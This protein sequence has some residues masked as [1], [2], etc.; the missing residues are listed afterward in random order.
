MKLHR[1]LILVSVLTL[2]GFLAGQAWEAHAQ[3]AA[4]YAADVAEG[5]QE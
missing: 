5:A 2:A 1:V 4:E 3:Y